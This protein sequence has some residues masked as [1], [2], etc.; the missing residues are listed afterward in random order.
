LVGARIKAAKIML[1]CPNVSL[2]CNCVSVFCVKK[3][4]HK[5][6]SHKLVWVIRV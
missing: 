6:F 1:F 3:N 2:E 5:K 4:S